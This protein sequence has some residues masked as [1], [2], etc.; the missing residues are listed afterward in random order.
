M[1]LV[2]VPMPLMV[3]ETHISVLQ[4]E[5]IG[6]DDSGSGEEDGSVGE[7]VV[8]AEP[9]DQILKGAFHLIEIGFAGED[10]RSTTLNGEADFCS[11]AIDRSFG[12]PDAG[13]ETATGGVEFG[14]GR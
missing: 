4:R 6:R 13:A 3:I 2:K 7:F 8:L 14:L 12:N 9:G 11:G 1:G 5:V 10:F